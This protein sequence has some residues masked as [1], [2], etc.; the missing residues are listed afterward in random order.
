MFPDQTVYKSFKNR[1][2][3][4]PDAP[5][6]VHIQNVTE[7]TISLK[8]EPPEYKQHVTGYVL[9]AHALHTYSSS[10]LNALEWKIYNNTLSYTM[11]NLHPATTYNITLQALSADGL[12]RPASIVATTV[13]GIPD[14]APITPQIVKVDDNQLTVSIEEMKN[15]NGPITA[16][17]IVVINDATNQGFT[18]EYLKSYSE[19]IKDG[20]PYY[21]TAEL[22]PSVCENIF[23]YYLKTKSVKNSLK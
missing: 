13:I 14:P 19:A 8:W 5:Q 10:V 16:Y 7:K 22:R 9:T 20:L 3:L 4:V 23:C 11:F 21:I 15:E 18:P 12:G 6:N 17:R 1:F 2:F